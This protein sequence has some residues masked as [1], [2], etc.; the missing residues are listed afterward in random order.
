MPV[1]SDTQSGFSK[2]LLQWSAPLA[3]LTAFVTLLVSWSD[4]IASKEGYE[5][6]G[7]I[8][9]TITDG[10]DLRAA[11][12]K[13][14]EG[15]WDYTAEYSQFRGEDGEWIATGEA[16][17]IWRPA[18]EHYDIYIGASLTE[19]GFANQTADLITWR[20]H[21]TLTTGRDGSPAEPF[22]IRLK[23]LGRTS[24]NPDWPVSGNRLAVLENFAI[25]K[26]Q[27]SKAMILTG[28]FNGDSTTAAIKLVRRD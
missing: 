12:R 14:L 28:E 20:F 11:L 8:D 4:L 22:E 10:E 5:R 24:S 13:P 3:A 23:Y 21:S 18:T 7:N 16:I 25:E 6:L 27:D 2:W 15:V 9:A 17:F 1:P 26:H 19:V